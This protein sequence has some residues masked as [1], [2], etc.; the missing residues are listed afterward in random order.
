M[1]LCRLVHQHPPRSM[2]GGCGSHLELL[3]LALHPKEWFMQSWHSSLVPCFLESEVGVTGLLSLQECLKDKSI[4]ATALKLGSCCL[5][6]AQHGPGWDGE[7]SG[8]FHLAFPTSLLSHPF[9]AFALLPSL[10]REHSH[11]SAYTERQKEVGT[12]VNYFVGTWRVGLMWRERNS[13]SDTYE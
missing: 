12:G 10:S 8:K 11:C 3:E 9:P 5:G 4:K 13:M 1:Q 6:R 2:P 7:G